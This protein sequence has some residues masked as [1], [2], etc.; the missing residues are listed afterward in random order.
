M[1]MIGMV[2]VA[3]VEEDVFDR[4]IRFVDDFFRSKC[5]PRELLRDALECARLQGIEQLVD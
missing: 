2:G 4:F 1:V 5:H 3:M